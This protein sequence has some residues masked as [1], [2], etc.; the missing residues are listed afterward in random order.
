KYP[1]DLGG[2]LR[3]KHDG[4]DGLPAENRNKHALVMVPAYKNKHFNNEW[5]DY[6]VWSGKA[7]CFTPIK[8][9]QPDSIKFFRGIIANA[10]D[11][12]GGLGPPPGTGTFATNPP[13][14]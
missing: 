12:H 7:D 2:R 9:D 3:N 10:G 4:L 14:Q 8:A 13:Q 6:D 1:P 5:Y 11:N